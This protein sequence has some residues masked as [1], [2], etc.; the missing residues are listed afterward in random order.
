MQFECLTPIFIG[1]GEQIDHINIMPYQDHTGRNTSKAL[2]EIH[3][4]NVSQKEVTT[5]FLELIRSKKEFLIPETYGQFI[6]K[7]NLDKKIL[8]STFDEDI[9]EKI[10]QN[11]KLGKINNQVFIHL[12]C[13]G[14]TG[15][16][17]PGSSIKG[18][19]KTP[20]I[21]NNSKHF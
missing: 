9:F 16:Y 11:K 12:F 3:P 6:E 20:Y 21:Q 7:H 19:L 13:K 4:E 14:R 18:M 17:V 10:E 8:G 1:S 15:V 5:K 2:Y